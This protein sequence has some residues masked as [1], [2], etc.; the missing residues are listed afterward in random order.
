MISETEGSGERGRGLGLYFGVGWRDLCF[1]GVGSNGVD[2][3]SEGVEGGMTGGGSGL[4]AE[5]AGT[6]EDGGK[7]K[8][9]VCPCAKI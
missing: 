9:R 2:E 1:G 3:G 5:A 4:A 6:S 8:N 7:S